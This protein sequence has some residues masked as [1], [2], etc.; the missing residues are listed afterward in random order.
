MSRVFGAL[1]P[2]GGVTVAGACG[3]TDDRRVATVVE[4][5]QH[6]AALIAQA[7]DDIEERRLSVEEALRAVA[8]AAWAAGWQAGSGEHRAGATDRT[9]DTG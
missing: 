5:D 9:D 6:V 4:L 1:D 7:L 8:D 3:P 2:V